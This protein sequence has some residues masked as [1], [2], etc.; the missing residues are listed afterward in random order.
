MTGT[1]A[2]RARLLRYTLQTPTI[3]L[4]GLGSAAM[5]D[6]PQLLSQKPPQAAATTQFEAGISTIQ[7]SLE[8][9]YRALADAANAAADRFSGPRSGTTQVGCT[10]GAVGT[11]QLKISMP[12]SC[13]AFDWHVTAARNGTIT[14]QRD[15]DG[16]GFA[17]PVKFTGYGGVTGDAAKFMNLNGKDFNGTFVVTISGVLHPDKSFCPKLEQPVTHFAWGTAPEID[18][19]SKTCIGP[20]NGP[21][22]CL[23]PWKVPAGAMLTGQINQSLAQQ[24]DAINGKIACEN[25][26][27]QLKQVWKPWSL[28]VTLPNSPTFYANLDPVAL[29]IPGVVADDQTVK[30]AARLDVATSVTTNPPPARSQTEL[31]ENTPLNPQT[32]PGRLD[33]HVPL[34]IPY[35]LLAQSRASGIVNQPLKG[36]GGAITPTKVEFFP[37]NDKLAVGVTFRADAPAKLAHQT[38]TVWYTATPTVENN[39]HLIKLSNI[40]MTGKTNS[41]LWSLAKPIARL[42]NKLEGSYAYDIAPLVQVARTKLD[43][44]LADPKNT[45]GANIKVANDDLKLGRTALLPDTFVVEGL[46]D[47][48]VSVALEEPRS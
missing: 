4:F 20:A 7:P 24:V 1:N 6:T 29:S 5:A 48:D 36:K 17:I 12:Q 13:V 23:G 25:V 26:R 3:F 8:I 28:P 32:A 19:A 37:D 47:A 21:K 31:P 18:V 22:M 43:Q 30:V 38:G 9:S 15:G 10:P 40:V 27:N 39:G 11:N 46:F 34:A 45:G 14:A 44:A 35:V 42:P 16:V 2:A 41:P 33:L